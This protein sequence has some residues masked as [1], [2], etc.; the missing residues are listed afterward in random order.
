MRRL[1][2]RLAF[3]VA[4]AANAKVVTDDTLSVPLAAAYISQRGTLD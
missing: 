2:V 4:N 3:V 1:L